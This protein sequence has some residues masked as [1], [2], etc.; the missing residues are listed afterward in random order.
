MG[1]CNSPSATSV[2]HIYFSKN[3]LPRPGLLQHMQ[4]NP[5]SK[6]GLLQRAFCKKC[7]KHF[8]KMGCCDS[9]CVCVSN[10]GNPTG[11]K[12]T[13]FRPVAQAGWLALGIAWS[14]ASRKTLGQ[15]QAMVLVKISAAW[16]HWRTPRCSDSSQL[17]MISPPLKYGPRTV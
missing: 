9:V 3:G 2:K 1:C 16:L 6:N 14:F 8:S 13:W 5:F 4:R 11:F 17:R 7:K 10:T 15:A 12:K